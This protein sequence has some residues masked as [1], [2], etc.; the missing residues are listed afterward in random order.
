MAIVTCFTA[1]VGLHSTAVHKEEER[2]EERKEEREGVRQGRKDLL[3]I[4]LC[5]WDA[6]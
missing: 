6:F 4:L 2:K 1:I 5:L 3:K